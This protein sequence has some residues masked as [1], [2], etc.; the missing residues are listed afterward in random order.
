MPQEYQITIPGHP[1][2][3]NN[4]ERNLN[5]Y[6]CEP[7]S[8]VNTNT[9]LLLLIPGFG[10]N[11]NSNVYKKMRR[12]FSDKYNLITI[13]CDYFGCEFMQNMIVDGK[14][15]LSLNELKGCLTEDELQCILSDQDSSLDKILNLISKHEIVL[16]GYSLLDEDLSNFNDMGIMQAIDN[17]TAVITVVEIIKDNG[18]DFNKGKVIAYGQSQGAYLA[19][20]CNAFAPHLFS[21]I[22]DNSAWLFPAYMNSYR[23]VT[24]NTGKASLSIFFDYLARRMDMDKEIL[25]LEILYKKFLNRCR[26]VSFNGIDDTLVNFEDKKRFCERIDKCFFNLIAEGNIDSI[27]FK[28]ADHGLDADFLNLFDHI[29]KQD[30]YNFNE[31]GILNFPFVKFETTTNIYEIDYGQIVPVFTVNKVKTL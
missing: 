3:Y 5:V 29:A 27:I 30:Y 19:Y 18:L 6:F 7:E 26:I 12:T 8:G 2:I 10:A 17:I 22:I 13:Q 1:S 23:C 4:H 21:L 31:P 9:G 28:S 24:R 16:K 15:T 11:A 14:F 20:L 25:N